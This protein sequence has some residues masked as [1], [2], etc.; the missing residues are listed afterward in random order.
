MLWICANAMPLPPTWSGICAQIPPEWMRRVCVH[1]AGILLNYSN[2]RTTSSAAIAGPF[3]QL[4]VRW[5]THATFRAKRSGG[6]S[7]IVG[8]AAQ[9]ARSTN[10]ERG[11]QMTALTIELAPNS[12][13]P[14]GRNHKMLQSLFGCALPKK[15]LLRPEERNRILDHHC[16]RKAP[17]SRTRPCEAAESKSAVSAI[18]KARSSRTESTCVANPWRVLA[19]SES[20]KKHSTSTPLLAGLKVKGCIVDR[21][22]ALER[23]I[24]DLTRLGPARGQFEPFGRCLRAACRLSLRAV[25]P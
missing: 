19:R 25:E 4:P 5:R 10:R 13:E 17:N 16:L 6:C 11:H 7:K 12:L 21:R 1:E 22:C 23:E 3:S 14:S 8:R 18:W 24:G 2:E 9:A 15:N 20:R